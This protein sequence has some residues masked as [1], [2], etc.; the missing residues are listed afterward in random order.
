MKKATDLGF[1]HE[2]HPLLGRRV[3]DLA[4]GTEGELMAAVVREEVAAH[5]GRCWTRRAYIRPEA[6]GRGLPTAVGNIEPLTTD[7]STPCPGG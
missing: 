2:K 5:T 3:R 7:R 4:A 6:G 1:G